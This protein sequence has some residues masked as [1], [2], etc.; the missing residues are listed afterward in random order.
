MAGFFDKLINRSVTANTGS[1]SESLDEEVAEALVEENAT[2]S[3]TRTLKKI[4]EATQE[5][6]K[7]GLLEEASKPNLYR[8]VLTHPEEVTRI[9]EPL[10][11]D[12]GIDEIRGLLYVKVRLDETPEQDEWSHPLVRR[13]RL[14][15]E[16]SLLVAILRQHFVAWEQE[17][18]TGASQAQI[19]I[20]DLLPQL[21]IYLGD[22][23]S[24]SKERTRL[25]T[26]LDQLKGHGLVT[27]PDA[28]ERIVIRPIIAH[29]ADP[30]NLQALL[31]WLREQIAR[32]TSPDNASEKDSSEE[33]V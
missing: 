18:G 13:Q 31:A 1:E 22:P 28:H 32:Q 25:L 20:D 17:S 30:M 26:L 23:G 14:N 16:Q 24:E 2:S 15:L 33:D 5:L 10:D 29:L 7:Y 3:E 6:L 8:V 11:L 27:S 19:A 12:I 9:L 4:R 21:Q